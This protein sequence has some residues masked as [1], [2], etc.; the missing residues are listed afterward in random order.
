MKRFS[1][2]MLLGLSLTAAADPAPAPAAPA[3]KNTYA[4]DWSSLHTS[5]CAKVTGALLTKLTK[6]YTCKVPDIGSASGK[7]LIAVCTAKK[8]NSEYFAFGS[9]KDCN[10]ERETQLANG[11]GE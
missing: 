5:K 6:S 2:A 7:P 4:F 8:G 11:N 3:I 1:V 9:A 10:E